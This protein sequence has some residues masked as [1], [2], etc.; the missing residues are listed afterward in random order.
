MRLFGRRTATDPQ[1][2]LLPFEGPPRDAGALFDR[3]VSLGLRGYSRVVLTSNATVMVSFSGGVLRVHRGYLDAGDAVHRAIVTFAC[4]HRRR[5]RA[6]AR[7]LIIAHAP[8]SPRASRPRRE[9]GHA[10]DR[11]LERDLARWHQHFNTVHFSG[12]LLPVTVR[13]S[14][15]MR[16][17]LGQYAAAADGIAAEIT[18]SRRHIRRHGWDEALHTLLH[19]MVHQWQAESGFPLDH[20]RLFRA[21]AR[22]LGIA[23]AAVRDVRGDGC[24]TALLA[25]GH[26]NDAEE[27]AVGSA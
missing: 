22:E 15:R 16:S 26:E 20:G 21:K 2:L 3:L 1:Q 5:E 4:S 11:P 17:R 14:R 12:M 18:I 6:E 19:E 24:A 9:L 8:R 10:E 27:R 25:E 13:V 23:A 7:R